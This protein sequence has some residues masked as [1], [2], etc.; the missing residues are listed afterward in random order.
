MKKKNNCK[1][2]CK[3]KI[4]ES[5]KRYRL[6]VNKIKKDY[7]TLSNLFESALSLHPPPPPVIDPEEQILTGI[8]AITL[9]IPVS[10]P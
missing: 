8:K 5:K 2:K 9:S 4:K 7:H 1:K 10:P 3:R 6:K